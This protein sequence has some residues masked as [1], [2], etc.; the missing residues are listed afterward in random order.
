[1]KRRTLLMGLLP[2]VAAC[3][4]G[5]GSLSQATDYTVAFYGDSITSGTHSSDPVVWTP[6]TWSPTPVQHIAALANVLAYDY[7]YN[8]A[9]AADAVV[10]ADSSDL[11]VIRFGVA[12]SVRKMLTVTFASNIDRL[13]AEARGLNKAVLLTGLPH[14][15][16]VD[17]APFD[18]VM[19]GR[20]AVLGVPFVDVHAL[21]FSIRP[22]DLADPLHPGEAYSRRI[23]VAIAEAIMQM[24]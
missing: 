9:S 20:A 21:P 3:G 11:V 23:G 12:D 15:A 13:V 2:L 16:S 18:E 14:A 24:K 8:G 19:R 4:G 1:M 5:G 7:S 6:E 10:K 22:S 17:T